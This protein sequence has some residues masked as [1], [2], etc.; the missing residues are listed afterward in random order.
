MQLNQ[1]LGF[2]FRKQKRQ[3]FYGQKKRIGERQLK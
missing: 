1:I 2:K 3:F